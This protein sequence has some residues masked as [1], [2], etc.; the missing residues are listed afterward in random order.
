MERKYLIF[1]FLWMLWFLS[2]SVIGQT[3]KHSYTLNDII[4]IALDQSP[5]A[6]LAR[7]RFRS[8]YWEYRTYRAGYLPSLNLDATPVSFNRGF[9]SYRNADGTYSFIESNSNAGRLSL[10]LSQQIPFSGGSLFISSDLLRQDNFGDSIRNI[11]Y[12]SSPVSIGIRQPLSFYNSYRWERKIEP[13]K[14]EQAKKKYTI[15]QEEIA[16]KAV[17]YFFD[18]LLAQINIEI[19]TA[20]F[21]N[22]DTILKIAQGRYTIGTIAKNDLLQ[23][24]LQYLNARTE[25]NQARLDFEIARSR[26]RS[27]LGY[28]EKID[29]ELVYEP[30]I[31]ALQI[32]QQKAID[33]AFANNP[34]MIQQTLQL[35]ESEEA[36]RKAW[37]DRLFKSDLYVSYGL[38]GL[39]TDIP[40]AYKQPD[41]MQQINVGILIPVID[42]GMGKGKYQMARSNL[43]LTKITVQQAHADFE[44]QVFLSVARF[45]MQY[46]QLIIAS[47]A[48]T[49]AAL[50]YDVS[51]QRF[52]IGKISTLDLNIA[53]SEKDVARRSYIAALH[54]YWSQF[55]LIRRLT[56]YDFL[57]DKPLDASF[58]DFEK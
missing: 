15:A 33:L 22:N 20:N 52:M 32:N 18:Q 2:F 27:F 45:N 25:L 57:S 4:A 3:Q 24:E 58:S 56:L 21:F 55:Y 5:D 11:Y 17:D 9:S 49:I 28:N 6:Y 43:E 8:S 48:D 50:R 53:G 26:L 16:A 39:G 38:N 36:V 34:E 13:L 40:G 44:Q 42:W 47:K 12:K 54:S 51:K 10:T 31:P 41:R 14:Y 29:I 35:L 46:E 23:I 37:S 7:H 1:C 19:S 30:D